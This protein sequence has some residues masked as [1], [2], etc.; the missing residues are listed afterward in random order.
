VAAALGAV[1]LAGGVALG[2]RLRRT[3]VR[4]EPAGDPGDLTILSL[5]VFGGRA[6]T[7]AVAALIEAETPDLVV[8]P[9]A[10]CDFRD[11]LVPLVVD[12]GYRGWAATPPGVPDIAGVVV[13]GGPRAGALEVRSGP[14]LHYRHLQVGGGILGRRE[15]VAVHTTAPRTR[16]LAARWR[17]DLARVGGWTRAVPA[18]LVVGDLNATL[19]NAPLRAAL[20]GCVSAA[21]GIV[22]GDLNATL[23]NAPLRA[24]LGGCVSAAVG[25]DR[26][27][28]TFP[29]GTPRWFGIQIDHVLVPAGTATAAFGVH[30]VAGTDHRAVV[31]RVRLPAG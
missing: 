13:L 23:D 29:A 1:G 28:G 8:L 14:E 16:R 24:A 11:K 30:D 3:A 27:T 25:V 6:D 12:L 17:R 26:L 4:A 7:A 18:P 15:L 19:D 2:A 10:G 9:E 21:V 31:A 20:G 22:V 5:N